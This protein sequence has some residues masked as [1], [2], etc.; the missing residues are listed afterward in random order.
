MLSV[1]IQ[2]SIRIS[3]LQLTK[4]DDLQVGKRNVERQKIERETLKI[5]VLTPITSMKTLSFLFNMYH[6][7]PLDETALPTAHSYMTVLRVL[8]MK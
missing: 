2:P 4:S 1:T 8:E 7:Y 6:H 3:L 5:V